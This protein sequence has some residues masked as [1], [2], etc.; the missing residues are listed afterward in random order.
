YQHWCPDDDTIGNAARD[1]CAAMIWQMYVACALDD[2]GF[3]LERAKSFGPDTVFKLA[4]IR[5]WVEAVVAQP[6]KGT[7]AAKVPTPAED[8]EFH[9]DMDQQAVLL[10]YR[11]VIED[12]HKK[13]LRYLDARVVK[14]EEP[15]VIAI[16]G[17]SLLFPES[18]DRVPNIV[19]AVFPVNEVV[20]RVPLRAGAPVTPHYGYRPALEKKNDK[21]EPATVAT[22]V[23]LD[24]NYSGIS[25]ILF[26]PSA[27]WNTPEE[28]R[29]HLLFVH[30]PKATNPIPLGTF[31]FGREYWMEV[32]RKNLCCEH[33]VS[34]K[35][36][37]G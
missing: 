2:H 3:A 10:R 20:Y 7:N 15:Y 33:W 19:R 14:P 18:D 6:G 30:N 5:H 23:F 34:G 17:G 8:I 4:G 24:P 31:S 12:K 28:T 1:A 29:D 35:R 32:Q 13:Y 16:N 27:I 36:T 9:Y 26:S 22:T 11:S 37:S 25:G 21:G